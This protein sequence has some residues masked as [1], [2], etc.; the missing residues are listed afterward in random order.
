MA[1]YDTPYRFHV[2]DDMP[3]AE[4]LKTAVPGRTY[5]VPNYATIN[6]CARSHSQAKLVQYPDFEFYGPEVIDE[7]H[8]KTFHPFDSPSRFVS[9]HPRKK[10]K[11]AHDHFF[12]SDEEDSEE[13]TAS[14]SS[15]RG[16]PNT[17]PSSKKIKTAKKAV[18]AEK[19][20]RIKAEES[21]KVTSSGESVVTSQIDKDDS[22]V[23]TDVS[24]KEDVD[25]KV[26][27]SE[28][29]N[30][31][32]NE[33]PQKTTHTESPQTAQKTQTTPTKSVT[34][35][36]PPSPGN[37]KISQFF[38]P[39]TSPSFSPSPTP[40]S[41]AVF[42]DDSARRMPPPP[43]PA[44]SLMP[45]PP[46]PNKRNAISFSVTEKGASPK[47]KTVGPKPVKKSMAGTVG[48]PTGK[49][50]S[51]IIKTS[52][53]GS[54]G[55]RTTALAAGSSPVQIKKEQTETR[56]LAGF[57]AMAKSKAGSSTKPKSRPSFELPKVAP[58]VAPKVLPKVTPQTVAL[59]PEK[60]QTALKSSPSGAWQPK[61]VPSAVQKPQTGGNTGPRVTGS[62]IP[63]LE[64]H[65]PSA[66]YDLDDGFDSD[67]PE[68]PSVP[69]TPT[70]DR[71]TD[72]SDSNDGFVTPTESLSADDSTP[73]VAPVLPAVLADRPEETQDPDDP[74]RS[75]LA[76]AG[77]P[78]KR[79]RTQ[80]TDSEDKLLLDAAEECKRLN[81]PLVSLYNKLSKMIDH[82]PYSLQTR[83]TRLETWNPRR[84]EIMCA[85]VLMPVSTLMA[86]IQ[87]M[88]KDEADKKAKRALPK[89]RI[90]YT[91][92]DD[93]AIKSFVS[94]VSP[95]MR[96]SK[97][98][99]IPFA[100]K[101]RHHDADS[102]K[103]RWTKTLSKTTDEA[104]LQACSRRFT[105]QLADAYLR[106]MTQ[107]YPELYRTG[108]RVEEG[109]V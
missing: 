3:R 88:R 101:Y 1:F 58:K 12:A 65:L 57:T 18:S 45:P 59:T 47:S 23:F 71:S 86:Q 105:P 29:T 79:T 48:T 9:L 75:L 2:A 27:I 30:S 93:L 63:R 38:P 32:S 90:P 99:Y 25:K 74:F 42:D 106:D 80:F 11:Q 49:M 22:D 26:L 37:A 83:H 77:T 51:R 5:L 21:S 4:E 85:P 54:P 60:P 14:K 52:P 107:Q 70:A 31:G 64:K 24:Q 69:E 82:S 53:G 41:P 91:N 66:F 55:A 78:E 7:I 39:K 89:V 36:K 109:S 67:V 104:Q 72:S 15:K 62:R 35:G 100:Q 73:A 94:Y 20:A 103:S 46:V 81:I 16:K 34:T 19:L 6:I 50:A 97:T 44:R 10:R 33:S 96:G 28:V 13:E 8:S 43:V 87:E 76:D 92:I 17:K 102:V 108:A 61:V 84:V 40:T 68:V 95:D 56:P 98:A